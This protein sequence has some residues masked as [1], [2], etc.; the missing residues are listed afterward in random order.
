MAVV[1]IKLTADDNINDL[2]TRTITLTE[3][4]NTLPIGRASKV[5]TKGFIAAADNAWF[6]SPVMSRNHAEIVASFP[7]KVE[8]TV[9]SNPKVTLLTA[10]PDGL[11]QGHRLPPRHL[12]QR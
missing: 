2:R 10:V 11:Y 5:A 8:S 6:D 3:V 1:V 4:N 12:Y 9:S 7:D